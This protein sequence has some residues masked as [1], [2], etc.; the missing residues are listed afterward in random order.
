MK[1]LVAF[2]ASAALVAAPMIAIPHMA[3]AYTTSWDYDPC[4]EAQ[5][6]ATTRGAVTGGVLGAVVGSAVAGGDSRLGGALV[7]GAVGAAAGGAIG[8]N[9]VKCVSYPPHYRPRANCH[10]VQEYSGG[11]T[12]SFEVCRGS[13]G[14]WRASGRR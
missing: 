8:H 1:S 10:W 12:H 14:V 7:G 4:K 2:A 3:L 6:S 13:D 5:K 11:R 9:S